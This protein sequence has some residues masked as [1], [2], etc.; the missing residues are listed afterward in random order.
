MGFRLGSGP[1]LR[2]GGAANGCWLWQLSI[3][4]CTY[5][6]SSMAALLNLNRRRTTSPTPTDPESWHYLRTL[7]LTQWDAIRRRPLRVIRCMGLSLG[8]DRD[9]TVRYLHA[10]FTHN[11]SSLAVWK[12]SRFAPSTLG[13]GIF[14]FLFNLIDIFTSFCLYTRTGNF[15]GGGRL[16]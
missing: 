7:T 11:A 2:P 6:S 15:G 12:T 9:T 16:E 8:R 14:R 3:V 13:L 1:G 4:I 5:D 10:P